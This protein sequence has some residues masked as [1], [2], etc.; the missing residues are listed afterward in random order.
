MPKSKSGWSRW[1]F[2]TDLHGDKQDGATCAKLAAFLKLWK[3]EIRVM[4]GDLWDFR[5]LRKKA[6]DDE[7][8]ESMVGDFNAG[9]RW[10]KE[11]Q[12]THFL[13]GNHDE[14]LWELAQADRGVESDYAFNG[15]R[16]IETEVKRLKCS[17]LPYDK[18]KGV[19]RIGHLKMLHGFAG[20]VYAARTHA[21][22]YG[23]C[24]FG[25]THAIDEHAIPGLERRVARN[26][27]CLCALNMDY[28][29][30]MLGTLK[31]AHG[32]AFG[33]V[34]KRTGEYHAWQAEEIGGQWLVPTDFVTL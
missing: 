13:R 23:S 7:R 32:W 10:L 24:L 5:P 31:Q 18:R 9:M 19:L 11:F 12:P 21:L 3:P 4:G 17:M 27:G 1:I 28:N 6:C 2:V 22:V 34:N 30:R 16:E 15:V 25:H 33:V 14:R 20:G 26:V 29:A 8:R